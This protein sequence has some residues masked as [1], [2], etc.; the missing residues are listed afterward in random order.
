MMTNPSDQL[1]AVLRYAFLHAFTPE[2]WIE[3]TR[4][5]MEAG[6]LET[7]LSDLLLTCLFSFT[8][9]SDPLI[10]SYLTFATT[11]KPSLMDNDSITTSTTTAKMNPIVMS[12]TFLSKLIPFGE[13][14]ASRN[15]YQWSFLLKLLPELLDFSTDD[16]VSDLQKGKDNPWVNILANVF[17]LLSHLVA[18]G[19]YPNYYTQPIAQTPAT[20]TSALSFHNDSN[21]NAQPFDSQFSFQS[22]QSMN[23]DADATLDMDNT[24]RIMDDDDPPLAVKDTHM[25]DP[26]DTDKKANSRKTVEIDN[27]ALAAQIMIQ[28]I[29]KRDSKRIFQVRNN[30]RRQAG[31][32][33]V[34]HEP[35]VQCQAKLEANK[36]DSGSSP[37]SA[38]SQNPHIQ[39]LLLLIQRLTD[40]DLERRM[41]VH[42][43][44]HELE[45]EGTARAMPSAGLMGLL[46]H[47]VQIRPALDDEY[48]IDHLLK[49]Q[50]I[51]GSFDES[52]F[53]EIWLTALTGLREASLNTSC[54]NLPSTTASAKDND[55]QDKNCNALVATNRLLWKSLV[56]VK[57]P[58]LLEKL[59]SKKQENNDFMT[60]KAIAEGEFNSF[61]ASLKELKAFSGLINACSPPACCSEFY[62]PDSMSS[63]LVDKIAFGQDENDDDDDIMKMINDMSYTSNLNTPTLTKSIR[64][65]S[66]NDIFTNIVNVCE[67]Y[68]FVRSSVAAD[69][70]K[71]SDM[72]DMEETVD[73][74]TPISA[75]DQN[76]DARC[77]ALT[78]NLSFSALT[79]LLHIGL[80]SP[81]HLRKIIDFVLSLLKQKSAANDFYALAKMCD[82]LS[83]CPCSVDLI[84]QL[85]TPA[86]LLGP[87]E[88][89]CTRWNPADYELE[90][91]DE[92]TTR[93]IE[94]E[95][96]LDGVQLLYSKFGNIW[97]FAVS[98]V[99]KFKLCRDIS[100]VF[101]DKQG[102]LYTYFDE[103]P[104]IYGVD[105]EDASMESLVNRWMNA[106]A[107]G[108]G[109][110]DEL[111]R[112]S[113]PQE[114]L[115]IVPTIMQRSILL[116]VHQHMDQDAFMGLISYFQKRFLN[117][118]LYGV[119]NY[120]CQE[121]LSGH[122]AVALA[123]LRQLIMSDT[124]LARDFNLHPV[125]GSLESLLE[126]KR[127]EA[128]FASKD[129]E[130][131][132]NA[133]LAQDMSELMQYIH[134]NNNNKLTED[135]SVL[136]LETVT[137]GVTPSTL[138]EKAELMFKYIVKSGRSMF[139]SDVDADTNSLW[140]DQPPSKMQVVSHYLDMVLF[141][142]ALEIGGGHW[143]VGMI[144]D[145]VLEA[146]RSGGAV[147]AAELGSCLVTT[148]LLYSA[149][150]HN[151]CVNLLRCLLQDVLPSRLESCAEQNMS[152]FQGQTLGV[153]ASDCLVLMQNRYETV[154]TL[155][156]WFF[157]ALVID[158]ENAATKK[159]QKLQ[160]HRYPQDVDGTQFATWDD[161]V[162]KSAV[163]R[164]FIKGLMSNPMIEE[165]WPNA[166]V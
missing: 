11:G 133:K 98:V 6:N 54:Q 55:D 166:F 148:P 63:L 136:F 135:H 89:I 130:E 85:Y 112:T 143:F 88:N 127:Q 140:D 102:L 110:S 39:K 18:V 115:H 82:A 69:L 162:T 107:G 122:S 73:K 125:L 76:I 99:K 20:V 121:L 156:R 151:S 41:A 60:E 53:L 164:G 79:E 134:N 126:F 29:E 33:E 66:S 74:M 15:P 158:K 14:T 117:F 10:E 142:T 48:I 145:Q 37:S 146:G 150:T 30:Q 154:K 43:K 65:I 165:I 57:L 68:G 116:H 147:R 44:Y 22:Q 95:D 124:S 4:E 78:T 27:A 49:L 120:L 113:T 34:D 106:L 114:L 2:Q 72:M 36:H 80:V 163:W 137:T 26:M 141:E 23:Y 105:V 7:E 118:A 153:F 42:M 77:E 28:L 70:T 132:S 64:S 123:S 155:G 111:L 129:D 109:V 12:T 3:P 8:R 38:A 50:T 144:V 157:E 46:Y 149:N 104:V 84:L 138:F 35:W 159:K 131:A 100:K 92:S 91:E 101:Q 59:Q 75:I 96:E 81:I 128:A 31:A 17:Q 71:K 40:R 47:M 16:I 62:A 86:D 90:P 97:S 1:E 5:C 58:H 24:Q 83:E 103:C 45:D 67:R 25:A 13:S 52:F 87:L 119:F 161:R 94:G 9:V 32:M 51:K 19:L 61:E 160:D 56:L 93:R 21:T 108:D 139:M 152:F